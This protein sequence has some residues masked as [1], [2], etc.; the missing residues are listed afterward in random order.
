[1]RYESAERIYSPAVQVLFGTVAVMFTGFISSII[2][3]VVVRKG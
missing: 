1:M 2:G 3:A